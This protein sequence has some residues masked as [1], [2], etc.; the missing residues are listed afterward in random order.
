MAGLN[1]GSSYKRQK[2]DELPE[3]VHFIEKT[4]K[5]IARVNNPKHT[6][7]RAISI[8]QYDL[9]QDAI[10]KYNEYQKGLDIL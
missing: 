4:K 8:G 2:K 1:Y 10:D 9:E 6:G 7:R 5:W 3:G